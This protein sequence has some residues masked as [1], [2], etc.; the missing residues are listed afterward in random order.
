MVTMQQD[1][2]RLLGIMQQTTFER[3]GI[4]YVH[5]KKNEGIELVNKLLSSIVDTQTVLYLSGGKT[6]KELYSILATEEKIIPGAVGMIDERFARGKFHQESNELMI[7]ESGLL[8]YLQMR[9]IPFYPIL[10]NGLDRKN[11]ALQY[12]QDIRKL[13][14]I[15][16]K[17]VGILGIGLDGHTAGLPAE[18]RLW[19]TKEGISEKSKSKMVIDYD[20]L[21]PSTGSGFYGERI[22]MTFLGLSMLDLL[23]VLIFGEDKKEALDLMFGDGPEEEIP[24]RFYKRPDIAKKTLLITDQQL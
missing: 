6:P 5:S 3:E 2:R 13:H 14:S 7:Q 16:P 18:V 8:R 17:S 24:S 1:L 15:F 4:L 23:I 20:D 9:D 12:D 10:K 21:G 19:R 11:T 22:T